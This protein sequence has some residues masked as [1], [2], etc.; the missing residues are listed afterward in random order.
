[1]SYNYEA[2]K[3]KLFTEDGVAMLRK[4]EQAVDS[5]LNE[6]GAFRQLEVIS[7][8]KCC[9]DSWTMQACLDYLVEQGKIV[10]LIDQCWGQFQVYSTPETNNY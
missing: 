3:P 4:I 6:A 2:E 5:L 7:K 1:M 9:G 10:C 8:A